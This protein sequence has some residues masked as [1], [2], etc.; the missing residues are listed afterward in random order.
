[1]TEDKKAEAHTKFQEIAFAYSIL[2]D[3]ARR[4]TYDATG[5][6]HSAVDLDGF[7]WTDFYREQYSYAV[8]DYA[9]TKF[10]KKYKKSQEEKEDILAA[11]EDSEGNMDG[12]YESVML[13][14]VVQDDKRFR[15]IIDAAIADGDVPAF[16]AYTKESKKARQKR[17]KAAGREAKEAE[18][19]A[20][21]LGVYDKLFGGGDGADGGTKGKGKGKGKGKPAGSEDA[22]A[23]IIQKRQGSRMSDFFAGMAKYEAETGPG[24]RKKRA[25][26]EEPPSEAFQA[27]AAKLK[28]GSGTG[29][30]SKGAKGAKT[31]SAKRARR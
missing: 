11:Y 3:V 26:E 25:A 5:S 30:G 24:K 22:L 1:M 23:A 28:K 15:A 16:D 8:S 17:L 18:E 2:S 7:N 29:D 21:E 10:A 12:I 19:R 14:D 4:K 13:S 20:R 6:T 27:A 31:G 9:I